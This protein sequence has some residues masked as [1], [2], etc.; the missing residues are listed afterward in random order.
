MKR[1]ATSKRQRFVYA[2]LMQWTRDSARPRKEQAP[3]CLAHLDDL[4]RPVIGFCGPDCI[5]RPSR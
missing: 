2:A 3:C 4:G 5:R 1:L